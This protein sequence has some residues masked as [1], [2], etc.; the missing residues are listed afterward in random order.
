MVK[1]LVVGF[2]VLGWYVCP[3]YIHPIAISIVTFHMVTIIC[4]SELHNLHRKGSSKSGHYL[5]KISILITSHL[6]FY[7][8]FGILER[9]I[10]ER[11]GFTAEEY[12]KTF[13]ILYEKNTEI[14]FVSLLVIFVM[15]MFEWQNRDLKYQLK[16]SFGSLIFIIYCTC[17]GAFNGYCYI[18]GGRWWIYFPILSVSCNDSFAYF[19]GKAFGKNHLIGL[20]PN[21]TI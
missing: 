18:I 12:P 16:K 20:S 9:G 6:F 13:M 14:C 5:L 15:L 1:R 3:M 21:K 11:S 2:M 17:F 7:P 8:R 19:A 10:L 4:L